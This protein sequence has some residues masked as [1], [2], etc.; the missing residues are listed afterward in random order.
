MWVCLFRIIVPLGAALLS[1][2]Y[3][4]VLLR[5]TCD[6]TPLPECVSNGPR[7]PTEPKSNPR[8]PTGAKSVKPIAKVTVPERSATKS[9]EPTK[10]TPAP[11]GPAVRWSQTPTSE[12]L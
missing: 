2:T 8:E 3:Y 6:H 11:T 9:D 7:S 5:G 10:T 4:F 1:G 12:L